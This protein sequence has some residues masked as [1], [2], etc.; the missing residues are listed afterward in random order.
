MLANS[1]VGIA[2]PTNVNLHIPIA[3]PAQAFELLHERRYANL[4]CGI[5][6]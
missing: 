1:T 3:D 4:L 2:C 6:A 5:R